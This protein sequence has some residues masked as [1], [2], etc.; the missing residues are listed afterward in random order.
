ML[1]IKNIKQLVQVR[2][3]GT[4]SIKG[5]A[6]AELPFINN[7]WLQI[8]HGIIQDYGMMDNCPE[9]PKEVI[10]ATGKLVIPA[11][12]DSHTHLVFAKT[13]E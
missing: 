5:A 13:R 6:M 11:W 4:D 9:D 8:K 3:S 7:A 12:C 10:D 1:L 2:E